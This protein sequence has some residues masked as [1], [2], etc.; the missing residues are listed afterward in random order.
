LFSA[1]SAEKTREDTIR[2]WAGESE[3]NLE[4]AME[5]DLPSLRS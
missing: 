2:V 3:A 4:E 5:A 1:G